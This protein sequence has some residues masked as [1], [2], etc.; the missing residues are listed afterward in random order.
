MSADF[1]E[2]TN[3]YIFPCPNCE[4]LTSCERGMVNCG[5]FRHG[6]F[7]TVNNGKIEFQDSIAPHLAEKECLDLVKNGKIVG[8]GK[9]FR[10]VKTGEK[11]V[12]EKCGYI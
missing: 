5:I 9:P 4:C 7:F 1:D 2:K 8:C 11:M 6:N 3:I 12:A 10:L